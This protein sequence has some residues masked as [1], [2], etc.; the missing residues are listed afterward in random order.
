GLARSGGQHHVGHDRTG[1]VLAGKQRFARAALLSPMPMASRLL[2]HVPDGEDSQKIRVR[3]MI[4]KIRQSL[5]GP[6]RF[7]ERAYSMN[8]EDPSHEQSAVAG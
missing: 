6:C 3:F 8:S 2:R 1:V 5:V 7:A 4:N